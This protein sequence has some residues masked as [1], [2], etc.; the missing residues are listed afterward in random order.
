MIDPTFTN[1]NRLLA[2]LFENGDNNLTRNSFYRHFMPLGEIK[3]FDDNK[4]FFDQQVKNK[5]EAYEKLVEILINDEYT[6]VNLL[7]FSY[8]QDYYKLIEWS[9]RF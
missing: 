3:D 9:K 6:T 7:G 1:I 8:H 4:P 5:H 2:L